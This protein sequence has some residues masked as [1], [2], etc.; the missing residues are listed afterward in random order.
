MIDY[1]SYEREF[2]TRAER[3]RKARP[4]KSKPPKAA[5]L[6]DAEAEPPSDDTGY[7]FHPTYKSSHHDHGEMQWIVSAL[8]QFYYDKL[9]DDVLRAVKGGKEASVYVC[10]AHPSTGVDFIAAKIYRPRMFRSLKNDALYREGREVIGE[11]GK[12]IKARDQRMKRAVDKMTRFGQ[13]LRSISWISHEYETLQRLHAAGAD[14]PRPYTLGES[15]ILMTYLG[16]EANPAPT[17][18]TVALERDEA[19]A[20]FER[21]LHNLELML[22]QHRV[23]ADLSAYN[24]LYWEGAISLIDFPQAVDPRVNRHAEALLTRDVERV[25]QYFKR[26]GVKADAARLAAGLWSRYMH[27]ELG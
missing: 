16:D 8:S 3:R 18:N 22:A 20:L 7:G 19:H 11:E 25:C 15:A 21:V 9:I 5:L 4:N 27:A 12:T 24:I 14:V 2:E 26:Y 23:H 6:P 1:E 10:A 13:V 17:L